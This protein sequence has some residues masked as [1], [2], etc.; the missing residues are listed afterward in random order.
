[1]DA[2]P[3][4]AHGVIQLALLGRRFACHGEIGL[5]VADADVLELLHRAFIVLRQVGAHR[6]ELQAEWDMALGEGRGKRRRGKSS[7]GHA[8]KIAAGWSYKIPVT[9]VWRV[10]FDVNEP[11]LGSYLLPPGRIAPKHAP[12]AV[13]GV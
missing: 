6:I 4:K 3:D 1:M 7:G 9:S 13:L 10:G 8:K 5:N 12:L 2:F 11:F